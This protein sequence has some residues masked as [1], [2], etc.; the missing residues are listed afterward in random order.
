MLSSWRCMKYLPLD[1]KQHSINSFMHK[2][3]YHIYL[4]QFNDTYKKWGVVLI[5][6]WKRSRKMY[7]TGASIIIMSCNNISKMLP[8]RIKHTQRYTRNASEKQYQYQFW[9]IHFLL[10]NLVI[11]PFLYT[12]N[13]EVIYMCIFLGEIF[14]FSKTSL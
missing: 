6:K 14:K 10:T 2:Y 4:T 3:I 13:L 11:I 1:V 12:I 8:K 5:K 7:R 9:V